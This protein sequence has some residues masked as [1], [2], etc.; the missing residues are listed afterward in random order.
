MYRFS[1]FLALLSCALSAV[2]AG[3][4]A[5]QLIPDNGFEQQVGWRPLVPQESAGK[6]AAFSYTTENPRSG[7]YAAKL[8]AEG[9]ARFGILNRSEYERIPVKPG[10]RYR[11]SGWVRADKDT[12]VQG[13]TPGALIRVMLYGED[14]KD[15]SGGHYFI[16]FNNWVG[17]NL[18]PP[19]SLSLPTDWVPLEAVIEIP[20]GVTGALPN[21][22]VWRTSGA[23][24]FDDVVFEKV[25]AQ[26]PP[27]PV[28][29]SRTVNLDNIPAPSAPPAAEL[30]T[31]QTLEE[32]FAALDLERPELAAVQAAVQAGDL[33]L[34]GSEL[35]SYLR[36][37]EGKHWLHASFN[38][39]APESG[40]RYDRV[41]AENAVKGKITPSHLAPLWHTFEDNVI[42]WYHNETVNGPTPYNREWQWQ[43]NRMS[44]WA[45]MASAYRTT[46][47]EKYPQ[48]WETQFMS[49]LA[50]CPPPP[51]VANYEYSTWRTIEAAIRMRDS[52]PAAY[53][54]FVRSPSVSDETLLLLLH[55]NLQHA[56]Y[57]R[58]FPSQWGNWLTMEMCGLYTIGSLFPEFKD[59]EVW[60]LEAIETLR[61]S[62]GSQF[63]VDGAQYELSPGYHVVS[64]DQ[65]LMA[66]P[67][68]ALATG[69]RDEIPA[70]Y[71]SAVEGGYDY[72]MHL[73]TPD[74]DL[75]SFND[76]WSVHWLRRVLA[77]GLM[78]FP[79]RD[80]W[81]WIVTDGAEG[82]APEATSWAFPFAGYYVMRSG[83]EKDANYLVLDAGP[84]GYAHAHQ[85]KLNLVLWAYGKEVLFDTG[86]GSYEQSKWRNYAV[87]T[88]S[89]NTVLVDGMPQH[90]SH[91]VM[92]ER[93]ATQANDV[94]WESTPEFDF[95]V[96]TYEGA[97]SKAGYG[98]GAQAPGP[99]K[100]VRRVLFLKPDIVIVADTLI[101]LDNKPHHYEA[102][103]HL[104]PTQIAVDETLQ[105]VT[106]TAAGQP[107]LVVLPLDTQGLSMEVVSGRTEPSLLGWQIRKDKT[108]ANIP[109]TTV[110]HQKE[111]KGTQTFV[112]LL[113]PLRTGE[114]S[115]VES[116]S[117]LSD[118]ET[119]VLLK[120]G[121]SLRVVVDAAPE[122]MIRVER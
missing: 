115:P 20:E 106:T 53:Q 55:S 92:A 67:R 16:G 89:H 65:N 77:N 107:N 80:D 94:V 86:G 56:L 116:V 69:R 103:W 88:Y 51:V 59:A 82:S 37:R 119:Q 30:L 85:D 50:Q 24:Y 66:I 21:L 44:F 104:L 4:V 10:E 81:R 33:T 108:P 102:R 118:T 49:F 90:R 91:Q 71:I 54:A 22:F 73:M 64:L 61:Q 78:F 52:W 9:Y 43:I 13:G 40:I 83:W 58:Q 7:K 109:A 19:Q 6:G 29:K 12:R 74:R 113:Y 96:G 26:T 112:T 23:V 100:H 110:L 3:S 14:G 122:G 34:A 39:A 63:L 93:V 111:G 75:P 31:T 79:E 18:E 38:P 5:R 48:A 98:A 87:S 46:A 47:D 1:F 32:L 17:R 117:R 27:T 105:S 57:L 25:S 36:Q 120:D 62:S 68:L 99:A 70:D 11:V 97:Y 41:R 28:A 76:S 114:T 95:V 84:L 60:R 8:S 121:T 42:N 35:V 72:L 45:D 15:A 2:P 101:P